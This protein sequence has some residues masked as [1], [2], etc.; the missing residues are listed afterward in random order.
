MALKSMLNMFYLQSKQISNNARH[1]SVE[2]QQQQ[3]QQQQQREQ[4][5]T[6]QTG[7]VDTFIPLCGLWSKRYGLTRTD[8][9]LVAVCW[10]LMLICMRVC[11]YR[12]RNHVGRCVEINLRRAYLDLE[13]VL[14]NY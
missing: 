9:R 2:R 14:K 10:L 4:N 1:T 3:Q 8:Y 13:E 6:Q 11:V 7:Q 5:Q 12:P